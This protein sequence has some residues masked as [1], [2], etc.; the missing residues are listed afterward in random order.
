MGG[1]DL[2]DAFCE[3]IVLGAL[4]SF[5]TPSAGLLVTVVVSGE[6]EVAGKP[7]EA[8]G[9]AFSLMGTNALRI[10][11]AVDSLPDSLGLLGGV[12]EGLVGTTGCVVGMVVAV[13]FGCSL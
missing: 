1:G 4:R 2:L 6:D 5:L 3:T 7:D 9:M 10:S 12:L 13:V 11:S 8:I